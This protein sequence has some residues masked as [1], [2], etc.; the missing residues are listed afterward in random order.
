MVVAASFAAVERRLVLLSELASALRVA[1]AVVSASSAAGTQGTA[2]LWAPGFVLAAPGAAGTASV[3]VAAVVLAGVGMVAG[4][5][6]VA[7]VAPG[8]GVVSDTVVMNTVG[9]RTALMS[10]AVVHSKELEAASMLGL[11]GNGVVCR[12][13]GNWHAR[14]SGRPGTVRL[15]TAFLR[16]LS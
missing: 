4:A 14:T 7:P 8:A 13:E 12:M 10:A 5:V 1:L 11:S 3:E 9:L 6:A 2:F 16:G 15:G